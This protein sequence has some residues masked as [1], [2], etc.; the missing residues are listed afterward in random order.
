MNSV[1]PDGIARITPHDDLWPLRLSTIADA[2]KQLFVRGKTSL[3]HSTCVAVVGSR[4]A[5]P[6][7]TEVCGMIASS[8]ARANITI[9]SGMAFGIDS[10]AHT[11]ALDADGSTIAVLGS[12]IDNAS[13]TPREHEPLGRRIDGPKGLII[14]EYAPGSPATKGS[15]PARNRIISG[16]S[17]ATI[18]VEA[19]IKSGSLITAKCALDQGRDVYAV[20]GSIFW[21]RSEGTN[22]LIA[23]GAHPLLHIEEVIE[24]VNGTQPSLLESTANP[25]PNNDSL[26]ERIVTLLSQR[27]PL[28]MDAIVETLPCSAPEAMI[29]LSMLELSKRIRSTHGIYRIT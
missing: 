3:L 4:R 26:E 14:S 17:Q 22:W 9:V 11:S 21:P 7:G 6:Y 24:R 18:I 15:Y 1:F 29:A 13:M 23:Q 16:I 8:L 25:A 27:G 20:P 5:S 28:H 10:I 2:P 12:G 19:D